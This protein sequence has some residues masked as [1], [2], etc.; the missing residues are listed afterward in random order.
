MSAR[1]PSRQRGAAAVEL[2]VVSILFFGLVIAVIEFA[3]LGFVYSSAVE[4][5]RLGAR[6]AAVCSKADAAKVKARMKT[7]LSL[8]EPANITITYPSNPCSATD[9]EPVTVAITGLTYKAAIPLVPL[10][11]P[12][13]A[14]STSVPA[15]SLD[16]TDNPLCT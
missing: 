7:M 16:S 6:V 12:V 9:C 13:P 15:E 3:K 5:T 4:A 8:L 11:F 10:D 1:Q 14:F 2:A